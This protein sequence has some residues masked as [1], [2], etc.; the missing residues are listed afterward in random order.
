MPQY[1]NILQHCRPSVIARADCQ[2]DGVTTPPT[3]DVAVRTARVGD[4]DGM[5]AV[6]AASWRDGLAAAL[7]QTALDLFEQTTF[8]Q[9]WRASLEHPPSSAH[10]AL[11]ATDSGEIVGLTAL[12]PTEEA[13]VGELLTLCVLPA[14]RGAGHGS[15]LLNAAVDTLRVN[16]FREMTCW[17]PMPDETTQQFVREAGMTPDGAYRDRVVD[18]S[19]TL[20]EV[21]LTAS[22]DA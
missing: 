22:I 14:S 20:R 9:T 19:H 4:A 12:A 18:D 15:R 10:R 21:R 2:N 3:P 1:Y 11:V 8:A 13:D 5:G 7:P 16:G 6:Q 17:V